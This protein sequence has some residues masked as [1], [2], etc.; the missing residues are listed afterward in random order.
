MKKPNDEG[1]SFSSTQPEKRGGIM[2]RTSK[3][4]DTD[5]PET[6][7]PF[8]AIAERIKYVSGTNTAYLRNTNY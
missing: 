1:Y 3:L 2:E 4:T 7:I 5:S 6:R 8:D